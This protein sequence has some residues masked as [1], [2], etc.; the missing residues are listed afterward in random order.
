MI[1]LHPD[2]SLVNA[3]SDERDLRRLS[4]EGRVHF[5]GVG[6]AGM[7]PL[8]PPPLLDPPHPQQQAERRHVAGPRF[9]S[10]G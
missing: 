3:P 8:C 4:N 9:P 1:A 7:C 2:S 10:H 6:G 5:M